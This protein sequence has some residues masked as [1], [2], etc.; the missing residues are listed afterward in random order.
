MERKITFMENNIL[1]QPPIIKKVAAYCRVSSG[2]DEMLHSLS[3]QVSYY[4]KLIQSHNDWQY[5]GVYADEAK[6]GTKTNR[7][8]FQKLLEDCRNGKIDL[9][10][11][12]S[13]SRFA[14]NTVTMLET[15]R[16]LKS[17][18][19]EVFFERENISS[20]SGDGELM[21]TILSS[22]AQEES[23]SV[24]DNCKWRLR[25][26][27][28]RGQLHSIN[29][30]GYRLVGGKLII[31]PTEAEVV[32]MIFAD[33][34]DG[35]GLQAIANKLNKNNVPTTLGG[36]WSKSTISKMLSCE[37]YVGNLLLQKTQVFRGFSHHSID[38][39]HI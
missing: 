21:L 2:K 15:V 36:Q 38:N 27:M 37:K 26:K 31:E 17:L 11:T 19:V 18:G 30:Y 13:I 25:D 9:V 1:S 14:R 39:L 3:A 7:P 5:A 33:Y 34:L 22:F 35:M 29:I 4:S 16:E 12:K 24:S 32:K 10:L 20:L 28:K 23:K 6:T 8:Q